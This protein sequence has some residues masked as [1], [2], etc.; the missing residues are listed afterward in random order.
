MEEGDMTKSTAA[1]SFKADVFE[2]VRDM[3]RSW[4]ERLQE[5]R[6]M[7]SDFGS[8][9]L[10]AKSPTEAASV[11]SEWMAKHAE[12]MASEQKTFATAWLGLI[13]DVMTTASTLKTS[14]RD[15]KSE[16]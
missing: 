11:C 7:E 8:R 13:L 6:Q 16:P 9:L 3:H 2:R 5:M 12:A 14:D 4:L 15:Q 10:T 1:T